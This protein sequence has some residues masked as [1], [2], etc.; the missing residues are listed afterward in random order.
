MNSKIKVLLVDDHAVVRAG[1]KLLLATSSNIEVV[2]EAESGE[3]SIQLY[4][5]CQPDIVVLDLSMP[6]VMGRI[7]V[8]I[9]ELFLNAS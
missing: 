8:F 9:R 7:L 6:G 5:S 4:Q 3:Q 2:A 1:F